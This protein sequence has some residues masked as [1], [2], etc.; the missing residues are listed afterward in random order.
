[1][2]DNLEPERF[3]VTGNTVR[4]KYK[5]ADDTSGWWKHPLNDQFLEKTK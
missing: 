4:V 1:M 3:Q 5:S 2:E